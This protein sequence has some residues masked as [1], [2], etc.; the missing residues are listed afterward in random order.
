MT[1]LV[2]ALGIRLKKG[3]GIL[4]CFPSY[5]LVTILRG[6][7]LRMDKESINSNTTA[8]ITTLNCVKYPQ[9]ALNHGP[10]MHLEKL[11]AKL[12]SS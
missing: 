7:M 10:E 1:R 6:E 5:N 11:S 4:V 2:T 12:R 3:K 9:K 8:E